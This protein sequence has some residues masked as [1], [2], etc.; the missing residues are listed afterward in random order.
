MLSLRTLTIA[1]VMALSAAPAPAQTTERIETRPFYGATVT[2][3]HG[4]R[5]IRPLPPHNRVI[6]NPNNTPLNLSYEDVRATATNNYYGPA[7]PAAA[8]ADGAAPV[9]GGYYWGPRNGRG[10]HGHRPGGIGRTG[11]GAGHGSHGGSHGGHGG[12]HGGG[13]HR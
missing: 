5:V 3:E 10:H 7:S 6:I 2:L 13:G 8:P 1:A 4:V 12:G 9:Y 11:H